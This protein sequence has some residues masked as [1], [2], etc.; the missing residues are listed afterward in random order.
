MGDVLFQLFSIGYI[1]LIIILIVF[2]VLTFS[3]RKHQLDRIEKK[4]DAINERINNE[5]NEGV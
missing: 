2:L 5:K 3:K 4:L 1:V